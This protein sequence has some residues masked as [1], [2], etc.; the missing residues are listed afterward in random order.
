MWRVD[1]GGEV[2]GGEV[3]VH[4]VKLILAHHGGQ[5]GLQLHV[6]KVLPDASMATW[7]QCTLYTALVLILRLSRPARW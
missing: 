4:Q 2:D 3:A 1:H 6:R 7:Y 5:D